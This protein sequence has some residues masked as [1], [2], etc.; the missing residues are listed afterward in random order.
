[1]SPGVRWGEKKSRTDSESIILAMKNL[2]VRRPV[3]PR[4]GG[5]AMGDIFEGNTQK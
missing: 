1:L 4:G 5:A 3:S 2:S